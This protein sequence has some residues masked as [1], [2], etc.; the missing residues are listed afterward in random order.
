MILGRHV[1]LSVFLASAVLG[2]TKPASASSGEITIQALEGAIIKGNGPRLYVIEHGVRRLIPSVEILKA[3]YFDHRPVELIADASIEM[4]PV[5]DP[6]GIFSSWPDGTIFKGSGPRIYLFMRGERHWIVSE[7]VFSRWGFRWSRITNVPEQTLSRMTEGA[8]VI[9]SPPPEPETSIL[10]GPQ[11]GS[12]IETTSFK[13][14]F[15]GSDGRGT[16]NVNFET[17]LNGFDSRWVATNRTD[18]SFDVPKEERRYTLFV[19]AVSADGRVDPTPERRSFTVRFSPFGSYV[20]IGSISTG[21]TSPD[22]ETITL[23]VSSRAPQPI[24]LTDYSLVSSVGAQ[25]RLPTVQNYY[26]VSADLPAEDRL[27]VPPGGKVTIVVG[28]TPLGRSVRLNAC[29]RYLDR[30]QG[31][32]T[33]L[34]SIG[35][36]LGGLLPFGTCP[37]PSEEQIRYQVGSK[38]FDFIKQQSACSMPNPI[39]FPDNVRLGLACIDFISAHYTYNGCVDDHQAERDFYL[40]DWRVEIGYSQK[41][42]PTGKETVELRDREGRLVDRYMPF[43]FSLY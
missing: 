31:M 6:L 16:R 36:S 25:F 37:S 14:A 1:F 3:F 28:R 10:S 9:G 11:E 19:R 7:K 20:Q 33:F 41:F 34:S 22:T 35:S 38:C 17:W 24:D 32:P 23:N 4:L 40:N 42:F 18:R 2:L 39:G 12:T 29:M 5:G 21:G 26:R 8:P 27:L 43:S 15:T 13:F 30:A